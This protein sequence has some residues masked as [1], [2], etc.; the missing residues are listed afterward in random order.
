MIFHNF[1]H[2]DRAI[3]L[4]IPADRQHVGENTHVT[5]K[6][7]TGSSEAAIAGIEPK[8]AL[9]ES[10]RTLI[11]E[12]KSNRTGLAHDESSHKWAMMRFHL[13]NQGH[14]RLVLFDNMRQGIRVR[15]PVSSGMPTLARAGVGLT[16][17]CCEKVQRHPA[18][19]K[20]RRVGKRLIRSQTRGE[21]Q[22]GSR[23]SRL[24]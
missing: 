23:S 10:K 7:L 18:R 20:A 13:E 9:H 3:E 8:R 16:G 14:T 19:G 21:R 24:L 12:P 4:L 15:P 17:G 1:E 6:T 22:A 11:G 5:G 2:E